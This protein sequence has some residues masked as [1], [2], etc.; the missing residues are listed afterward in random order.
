[1][2]G[3]GARRGGRAGG[4]GIFVEYHYRNIRTRTHA[5]GTL[6]VPLLK[7]ER[8]SNRKKTSVL[9][10]ARRSTPRRKM[11]VPSSS[12]TNARPSKILA[13]GTD[14]TPMASL[15]RGATG[16]LD[17]ASRNACSAVSFPELISAW[18]REASCPAADG[19]RTN[20]S[21]RLSGRST[22]TF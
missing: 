18:M 22:L 11:L 1:V 19:S 21:L 2:M 13:D 17:P 15:A 14:H 4:E 6:F 10:D 8:E 12:K 20:R 5:G 7:R 3:G 9:R 16:A